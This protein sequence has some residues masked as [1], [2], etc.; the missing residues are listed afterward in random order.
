MVSL[1]GT[2]WLVVWLC[3]LGT[4]SYATAFDGPVGSGPLR[5]PEQVGAQHRDINEMDLARL[6]KIISVSGV[7]FSGPAVSIAPDGREMAFELC[8]GDPATNSPRCAWFVA[9]TDGSG[10]AVNIGD[11]GD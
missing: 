1:R 7:D 9:N 3:L 6:R 8:E 11:A 2:G 10:A 5:I 4:H